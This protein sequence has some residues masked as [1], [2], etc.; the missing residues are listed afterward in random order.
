MRLWILFKRKVDAEGEVVCHIYR[1]F[2]YGYLILLD[3]KSLCR[4]EYVVDRRAYGREG[5]YRVAGAEVT[6]DNDGGTFLCI[7][8]LF[9]EHHTGLAVAGAVKVAHYHYGNTGIFFC[10]L[11]YLLVYLASVTCAADKRHLRL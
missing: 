7:G 10:K 11:V 3:V 9:L 8:K 2:V 6:V 1:S 5:A 4:R